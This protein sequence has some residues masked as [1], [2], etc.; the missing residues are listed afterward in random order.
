MQ[1]QTQTQNTDNK[2][3]EPP[4]NLPHVRCACEGCGDSDP[5]PYTAMVLIRTVDELHVDDMRAAYGAHAIDEVPAR[6]SRA[7]LRWAHPDCA[8]D[9]YLDP[10][11][12]QGIEADEA[13]AEDPRIAGTLPL[14]A[15][16]TR[17]SAVGG[18]LAVLSVHAD[19]ADACAVCSGEDVGVGIAVVPAGTRAGELV[20]LEQAEAVDPDDLVDAYAALEEE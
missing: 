15:V 13:D 5:R 10:S 9:E 3:S 4:T 12:W 16:T 7:R 8:S 11:W 17:D 2:A 1:T 14:Y 18:Y 6:E 20:R 19:L